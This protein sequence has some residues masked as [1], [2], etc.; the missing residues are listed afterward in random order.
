MNSHEKAT[1]ADFYQYMRGRLYR[2]VVFLESACIVF[3][4]ASFLLNP[5]LT[6]GISRLEAILLVCI[7]LISLAKA[8]WPS[9]LLWR[10]GTCLYSLA[11]MLI[12]ALEVQDMAGRGDPFIVPI[13][14]SI[15]FYNAFVT[16]SKYDCLAILL[17]T[18]FAASLVCGR[19]LM[20]GMAPELF[21]LLVFAVFVVAITLNRTMLTMMHSMFFMQDEF[22]RLAEIDPLTKI[23][24]RRAL[25][26]RL[27]DKLPLHQQSW[28]WVLIDLDDFKQINDRYGH[29]AGD[30][31]LVCFA[32]LLV[33]LSQPAFLG[34][35]GG[36]EFGLLLSRQ[37]ASQVD[38]LLNRLQAA[39]AAA[40]PGGVCFSFSAGV[41]SFTPG[42]S[43]ADVLRMADQ[44]MYAAKRQGKRQVVFASGSPQMADAI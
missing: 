20:S 25:F 26:A 27:D 3:I 16:P 10:M 32:D 2:P 31:V 8:R 24:N 11:L 39:V 7:S 15:W 23:P 28:F 18:G 9:I 22:R 12:S 21:G 44:A 41:A 30:Q 42:V 13:L 17:L 1:E 4:I 33:R 35:I 37:S 34:R 19:S 40:R 14:I 5:Y 38:Q 36:E 29:A 43:T 6:S